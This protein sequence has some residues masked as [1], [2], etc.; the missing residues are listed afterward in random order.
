[1]HQSLPTLAFSITLHFHLRH[2]EHDSYI[3]FRKYKLLDELWTD[4]HPRGG[5][6]TET[7]EAEGTEEGGD[8]LDRFIEKVIQLD[9]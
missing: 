7:T 9:T 3:E 1:M 8:R 6:E 5:R 2:K 4:R